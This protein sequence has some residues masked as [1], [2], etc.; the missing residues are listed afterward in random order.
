MGIIDVRLITEL[1]VECFGSGSGKL[2][3]LLTF[4]QTHFIRYP[5]LIP[6]SFA[7][8]PPWLAVAQRLNRSK[9]SKP[10]R[11]GCLRTMSSLK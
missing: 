5:Y 8:K 9:K 1:R 10:A 11:A 7:T 6:A 4:D 2:R 3:Y